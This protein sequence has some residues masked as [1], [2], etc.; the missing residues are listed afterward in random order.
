[1]ARGLGAYAQRIEQPTEIAPALERAIDITRDG[2]PAVLEFITCEEPDMAI[3][4][5]S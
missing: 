1:M 2:K 5:W 4:G 3:P